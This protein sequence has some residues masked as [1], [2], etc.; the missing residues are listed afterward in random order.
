VENI[1]LRNQ[2]VVD[3]EQMEIAPRVILQVKV[4]D[5]YA[6]QFSVEITIKYLRTHRFVKSSH[7]WSLSELED[8]VF[9]CKSF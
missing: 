5:E 8:G 9:F 7:P 3:D 6:F 2:D 4:S 1:S